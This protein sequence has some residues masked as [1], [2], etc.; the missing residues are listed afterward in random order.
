MD[1]ES[2]SGGEEASNHYNRPNYQTADDTSSSLL[3]YFMVLSRDNAGKHPIQ[4]L[5]QI[6]YV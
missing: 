5:T 3:G 1:N 6:Y 2:K 4:M